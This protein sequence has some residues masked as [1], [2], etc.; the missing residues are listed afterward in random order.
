MR[1]ER[2]VCGQRRRRIA[3]QPGRKVPVRI[4]GLA[5]IRIGLCRPDRR[6]HHGVR[7]LGNVRWA[8]RSGPA[9]GSQQKNQRTGLH[10]ADRPRRR[11]SSLQLEKGVFLID[12]G[13]RIP[14]DLAQARDVGLDQR[15]EFLGRHAAG[16]APVSRI[17][18]RISGSFRIFA[19]SIYRRATISFGVPAG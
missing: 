4:R 10:Q 12:P 5:P 6:R 7:R 14:D 1:D 11:E 3:W 16:S 17:L 15:G 2:A 9:A 18:L 13:A 19:T 8:L